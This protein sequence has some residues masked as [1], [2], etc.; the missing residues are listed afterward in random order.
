MNGQQAPT[1]GRAADARQAVRSDPLQTASTAKKSIIGG[2][3]QTSSNAITM[4]RTPLPMLGNSFARTQ[5]ITPTIDAGGATKGTGA[6][7]T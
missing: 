7:R 5:P 3:T 4:V 1:S 6:A 2:T